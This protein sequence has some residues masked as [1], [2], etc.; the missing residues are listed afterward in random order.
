MA[1]TNPE[2]PYAILLPVLARHF[3]SG[4]PQSNCKCA[5]ALALADYFDY[6]EWSVIPVTDTETGKTR[7]VAEFESGTRH[8]RYLLS[9]K[10]AEAVRRFDAGDSGTPRTYVLTLE[11]SQNGY[12]WKDDCTNAN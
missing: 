11:D 5:F 3:S 1:E 6:T 9:N 12:T 8:A 10:A 7:Y 4:M 2:F